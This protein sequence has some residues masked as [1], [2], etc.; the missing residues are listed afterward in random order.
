MATIRRAFLTTVLLL[1]A[2]PMVRLLAFKDPGWNEAVMQQ[3]LP[4]QVRPGGEAM[5]VGTGLD[6]SHVYEIHLIDGKND[7]RVEILQQCDTAIRFR[8]PAKLDRGYVQIAARVARYP[9]LLD[10]PL[11]LSILDPVG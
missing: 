10:Q 9:M 1:A 7:H 6:A 5:I 4:V 2:I 11:F 8:I 3:V